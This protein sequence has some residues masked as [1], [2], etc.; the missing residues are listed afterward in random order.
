MMRILFLIMIGAM[1]IATDLPCYAESRTLTVRIETSGE[2]AV[3]WIL[4]IRG[5]QSELVRAE[6]RREGNYILVRGAIDEQALDERSLIAGVVM[7]RDGKMVSTPLEASTLIDGGS[8]ALAKQQLR[9]QLEELE[10]RRTAI[11]EKLE[12][13]QQTAPLG[14]ELRQALD[15]D[16]DI[17]ALEQEAEF[18]A[19]PASAR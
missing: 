6:A 3:P 17:A 13:I 1:M 18:P 12:N 2:P 9:V 10:N 4:V 16:R 8:E 11:R 5:S 15:M 14:P 19:R 7:L